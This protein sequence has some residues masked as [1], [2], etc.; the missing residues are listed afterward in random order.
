MHIRAYIHMLHTGWL[1]T[2]APTS[3]FYFLS[4]FFFF[5]FFISYSCI[6]AFYS[7]RCAVPTVNANPLPQHCTHQH[8]WC[9]LCCLVLCCLDRNDGYNDVPGGVQGAHSPGP[10]A[11]SMGGYPIQSICS[12]I[13][14]T[15]DVSTHGL[16]SSSPLSEVSA[17]RAASSGTRR[18]SLSARSRIVACRISLVAV[19]NLPTS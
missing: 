2:L 3:L 8:N 5:S 17:A 15:P 6:V 13:L 9:V 16:E 7:S 14:N 18:F 11:L 1:K 19:V 12:Q 4:S 10:R